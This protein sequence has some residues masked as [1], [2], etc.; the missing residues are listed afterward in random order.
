MIVGEKNRIRVLI[1]RINSPRLA[2]LIM[3]HEGATLSW[4]AV[5]GKT[6]RVQFT[7]R[8][9][10]LEWMD[11]DGDVTATTNSAGMTDATAAGSNRFYRV[12]K[13]P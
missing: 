8:P 9:S 5:P 4:S 3:T 10:N 1:N 12:I 13:L 7:T 6:Y 11:L 2:P